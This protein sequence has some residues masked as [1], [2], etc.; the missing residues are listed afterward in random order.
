MK[1]KLALLT[2]SLY[3]AIAGLCTAQVQEK[4]LTV[5]T[6]PPDVP[7]RYMGMVEIGFLYGKTGNTDFSS[8]VAS[9]T[10]QL[11][12]GYRFQRLLALGGTVGF[13]FYNNVLVTPIALGIRGELLENRVSPVYGLDVGYGAVLL[14]DESNEQKHDG[15]WMFSPS[16]GIRVNTGNSTAYTFG[17]GYKTQ[18]ARTENNW[19]GTRTEQKINYKRLSL[20]MGFLF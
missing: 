14:S 15:G 9:P 10:V 6:T 18:R 12:N 8:S 3:L 16:A 5:A 13:D 11:F 19:W 2:L 7:N 1:K 17:I 20:R 4:Y